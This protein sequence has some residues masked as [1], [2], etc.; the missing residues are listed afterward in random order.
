MNVGRINKFLIATLALL[1][2]LCT[3]SVAAVGDELSV[4]ATNVYHVSSLHAESQKEIPYVAGLNGSV[5]KKILTKAGYQ[6][7]FVDATAFKR[8]VEYPSSWIVAEQPQPAKAATKKLLLKMTY[9][10]DPSDV[11]EMDASSSSYIN[12]IVVPNFVGMPLDEARKLAEA[13]E[14]NLESEDETQGRGIWNGSNWVVTTQEI[15]PGRGAGINTFINVTAI[16]K[17]EKSSLPKPLNQHI[18]EMQFYGRVTGYTTEWSDDWNKGFLVVDGAVLS[19]DLIWPTDAACLSELS[20]E[21]A[22]KVKKSL[23][24]IGTKVNVIRGNPEHTEDAFVTLRSKFDIYK[25]FDNSGNE[26]LVETGYW[27]PSDMGIESDEI[28]YNPSANYAQNDTYLTTVERLFAPQII[29]AGNI[30][31]ASR[32]G[33]TGTCVDEAA[34]YWAKSEADK[35]AMAEQIR[36]YQE[37]NTYRSNDNGSSTQNSDSSS[38]SGTG[39]P[40]VSV[41]NGYVTLCRDGT[42]SNSGGRRGACSHHGGVAK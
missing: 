5:A 14:F 26:S 17:G 29:E 3:G 23:F 42:V 15:E 10:S 11:I 25:P 16:K 7:Q 33:D 6:T 24:P 4:S 32:I 41:G 35:A 22:D 1:A 18:G 8:K 38:G 12:D 39:V 31:K 13:L 19:L 30:S 2:M 20:T 21:Q 34:A 27:V 9:K 37:A 40:E 36:Q 28:Q